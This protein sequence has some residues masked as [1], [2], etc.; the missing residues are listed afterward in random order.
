MSTQ[1]RSQFSFQIC[2]WQKINEVT[3]KWK[4][5]PTFT[6][7]QE[8]IRD[9]FCNFPWEKNLEVSLLSCRSNDHEGVNLD[10][11]NSF[12]FSLWLIGIL[13]FLGAINSLDEVVS[14]QAAIFLHLQ[15]NSA[16]FFW[17]NNKLK[18]TN[19]RHFQWLLNTKISFEFSRQKIWY[20][21]YCY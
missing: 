1:Q 4:K 20:L 5:V 18:T 17:T 12:V 21:L 8:I 16:H 6:E 10:F 11:K 15:P 7:Q 3:L 14:P 2:Q 13:W 19:H 9:Q